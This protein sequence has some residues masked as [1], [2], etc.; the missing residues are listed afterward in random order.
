[1]ATLVSQTVSKDP[2]GFVTTENVYEDLN[3]E[4]TPSADA[5]SWSQRQTDGKW[6]LTETFTD[7]VTPGGGGEPPTYPDTWSVEISTG[8]EPIE[9]HPEFS[10]H[11]THSQWEKYR[12]W[13]N[14]APD[15]ADWTP[16]TQMGSR[17]QLLQARIDKGITTFLAPKIVVKHTFTLTVKPTLVAVGTRNFPSFASGITP[18][19]V[20]FIVTGAS[21]TQDGLLYRVAYEWLGS[22]PGGWDTLLYPTS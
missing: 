1:M 2:R 16:S 18:S 19:G 22:A 8:S 10:T 13:R 15:P 5:R 12:L 6:V 7:E 4:M 9:S 14:G 17:G 3:A 20:D 21:V 11:F